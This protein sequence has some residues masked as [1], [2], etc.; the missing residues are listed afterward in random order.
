MKNKLSK[1]SSRMFLYS[2]LYAIAASFIYFF[3]D[4]KN[5]LLYLPAT[6]YLIKGYIEKYLETKTIKNRI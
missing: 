3:S 5:I 1:R 4:F 6:G 2:I